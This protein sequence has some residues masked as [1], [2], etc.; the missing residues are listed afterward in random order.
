MAAIPAFSHMEKLTPIATG[1]IDL[2]YPII[3][4][5]G[6]EFEDYVESIGATYVPIEGKGP[7]L[8][9]ESQMA[10]FLTLEGDEREIFAFKQIFLD[11][12]PPQ[13]R[14]I[15]RTFTQIR[16]DYGPDQPLI[17]I[18][19]CSFA[20]IAPVLKGAPGIRPDAAFSIGLAPYSGA[21]ND[22][23]PFRSGRHPDT[24]PDSK[25]I[26][27]ETQQAQ[28][29]M[30][31]DIEVNDHVH[32]V[33]ADMGTTSS[34]AS[35]FDMMVLASDTYLQYGVPEFEYPR[36]DL[37]DKLRFIGAPLAVGIAERKLPS[38]WDDVVTAKKEG[39]HIVAVTMSGAIYDNN[40]LI[41]PAL[42]ALGNRED[43]LIVATLVNFEPETLDFAIPANA[44]VTR[45]FPLDLALPDVD[46]LIS[47]G[48]FGTVQQGLKSGTPM[49]LS[50]VGQDKSQT[51]GILNY[52]G[53]GI[54][55]PVHQVDPEALD[56]SLD[57]LLRNETY[58][59]KAKSLAK[60]Y[61][62]YDAM[63]IVDEEIQLVL[64]QKKNA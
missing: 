28:E 59:A 20:G 60:E 17:Y 49:L 33:L 41:I 61:E 21:S 29:K 8:M 32:K 44:R 53:N 40:A 6:P 43:L 37:R 10:Q 13:H 27:F 57:E 1:L 23:F 51:G 19:D 62:K 25:K 42:K 12:I 36:S 58:R 54:Y 14:T 46:V 11:E 35:I 26:H 45:F 39:K 18:A 16:K 7:S 4:I 63:K 15:Q 50:G 3:F 47:N 22:S 38:W 31:P 34:Y 30:Y 5:A 52:V 2:G 55:H 9:S 24:S 48:G 64:K 56:R